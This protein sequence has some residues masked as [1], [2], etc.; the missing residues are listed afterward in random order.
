VER[1]LA[2]L[3]V[4]AYVGLR[5]QPILQRMVGFVNTLNKSQAVVDILSA[6]QT[7]IREWRES[8]AGEPAGIGVTR[9]TPFRDAIRLEGVS[10]RYVADGP[11]VLQGVDLEIRRGEFIGI[12]GPTGG[13]KS[14]LVD[15]LV[16]L[17]QPTTGAISVDGTPL[18]RRPLWWWDQLGVVSQNVFL[19]DDT[20]RN[21][22]A[23]GEH[24]GGSIDEDR[25][26]R[27]VA[28]AQ[29]GPVI[30][31]LEEGL[32]TIVGERGVRLSGGQRQ[33]V[34]IAR[35]LYREPEVL[36]L[37][38]GTSALDGAT[39]RAL[40]AAIDEATHE[41]TLIAIAHR[42]STIRDADRILVVA[43][44]KVQDIGT[45]DELLERSELF[46]ALA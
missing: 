13:G 37:D 12:C 41:R 16:G 19:M 4:F 18:G 28:R 44:G 17:L 3:A 31:Q 7:L 6:D 20:L 42:I 35:A 46:R 1:T 15:L 2:T 38:E 40:V 39:E 34:A 45:H 11:P 27:C 30:G 33:R 26:A 24:V 5:L 36:V 14:T 32:D 21:N 29:L 22:I 23:F 10:F 8:V 9:T 43:D 25:M